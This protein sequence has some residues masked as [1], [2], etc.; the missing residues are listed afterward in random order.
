MTDPK[1]TPPTPLQAVL[2]AFKSPDADAAQQLLDL[3]DTLYVRKPQLSP[4]PFVPT[5]AVLTAAYQDC[6]GVAEIL[7]DEAHDGIASTGSNGLAAPVDTAP[8]IAQVATEV[9]GAGKLHELSGLKHWRWADGRWHLGSISTTVSNARRVT[10]GAERQS[11]CSA[12]LRELARIIEHY[13]NTGTPAPFGPAADERKDGVRHELSLVSWSERCGGSVTIGESRRTAAGILHMIIAGESD[14]AIN[15]HLPSLK[16]SEALSVLRQ[17][18]DDLK[19]SEGLFRAAP[20]PKPDRWDRR[21]LEAFRAVYGSDSALDCK[22]L[23]KHLSDRGYDEAT[24]QEM[25]RRLERHGLGTVFSGMRD[26]IGSQ[27][28]WSQANS[29]EPLLTEL[30]TKLDGVWGPD[31]LVDVNVEEPSDYV[32]VLRELIA[33]AQQLK[34]GQLYIKA[35]GA[36]PADSLVP[37]QWANGLH[38][39]TLDAVIDL[40]YARNGELGKEQDIARLGLANLS[41]VLPNNEAADLLASINALAEVLLITNRVSHLKAEPAK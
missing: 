21:T 10:L 4:M 33:M 39:P 30:L 22:Q 1:T 24:L 9:N 34:D 40:L 31:A 28:C 3:L 8:A 29:P 20:K 11:F 5:G 26:E 15:G 38:K 23:A 36:A 25:M 37:S 2:R 41:R 7:V 18:A 27:D 19:E 16:N 32:V 17:L 35:T 13:E 6:G 12:E 14:D